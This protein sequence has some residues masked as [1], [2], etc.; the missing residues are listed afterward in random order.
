MCTRTI[1]VI[2][3]CFIGLLVS[4]QKSPYER[5]EANELARDVRY[6]SLFLGLHMGMVR[7]DFYGACWE[8]NKQG[9]IMQ[10]P[11]NLSVQYLIDTPAVKSKMFMRFYPNFNDDKIHEMP[12]EFIYEAWAPWNKSLSSDSLL[13]DVK[14]LLENWYG[15]KF[16]FL[17]NEKRNIK[18]WVKVD[19]NRRIRLYVKSLSTV[20]A[21]FLDITVNIDKSRLRND[22]NNSK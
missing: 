2:I 15:G 22:P 11:G 10:G 9:L 20:K 16:I 7:K 14:N 1:V 3:F 18:L 19:G 17:E 12:V 6:D 4:C 8:M 5:L 13:V 21:E